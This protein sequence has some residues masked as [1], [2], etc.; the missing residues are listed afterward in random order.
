MQCC[1]QGWGRAGQSAA[2][3]GRSLHGRASHGRPARPHLWLTEFQV[4]AAY[5]RPA[6]SRWRRCRCRRARQTP[7][8]CRAPT[9]CSSS[10]WPCRGACV[11]VGGWV[12]GR[13]VGRGQTRVEEMVGA[14]TLFFFTAA[15]H[16]GGGG[17]G[18]IN[19]GGRVVLW[20][21]PCMLTLAL[22]TPGNKGTTE[23]PHTTPHHTNTPPR[24]THTRT[25]AHTNTDSKEHAKNKV[26]PHLTRMPT[27]PCGPCIRSR[28]RRSTRTEE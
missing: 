2:A 12:C 15:L 26:L 11:G 25:H 14:D 1:R 6:C 10:R 13:G 8:A 21:W 5:P 19:G 22:P 23:S 3:P 18:W 28:T 24:H 4:R 20:R 16:R 7:P 17:E 9:P 27:W